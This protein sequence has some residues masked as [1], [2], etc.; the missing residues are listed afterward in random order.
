MYCIYG[1]EVDVFI[2]F[3]LSLCLSNGHN[4]PFIFIFKL[5]S[6]NGQMCLPYCGLLGG[7]VLWLKV[8]NILFSVP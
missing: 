3:M 8:S 1:A 4:I 5:S 6:S 7:P 2:N